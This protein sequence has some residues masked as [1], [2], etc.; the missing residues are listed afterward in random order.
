LLLRRATARLAL[1]SLVS[2]SSCRF[3]Q[4]ADPTLLRLG[5]QTLHRSE[6]EAYLKS[7][8]ARGGEPLA[9]GVRDAMLQP[10][11]EERVVVLEARERGLLKLQAGPDEEAR[12]V[13]RLLADAAL[14]GLPV[15][16]AEVE[17]Y[18]R[19]HGEELRVPERVTLRQIL[20]P[21]SVAAQEA[22]RRVA[23]DPRSFD[24]MARRLSRGPEASAGGVMG[25][26]SRGQLPA[27]LEA[28]A[29]ALL[30]SATSDVIPT[31]LGFHVLRVDARTPARDRPLEECRNEIRSLLTGQKSDES[32]RQFVR[33]LLARAKVNHEAAQSAARP[34]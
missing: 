1:L 32:V 30:P 33:G 22:R 3:L 29:F 16:D 24:L 20:L 14:A 26:F 2:L 34:S 31:P 12:A 23:S 5:G 6:F 19:D 17:A 8:E 13:R 10:F 11:L 27:E 25:S 21:T 18:Y 9:P 7:L 28:A 4:E 15:T